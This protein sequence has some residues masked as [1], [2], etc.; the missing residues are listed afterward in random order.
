[1]SQKVEEFKS[2]DELPTLVKLSK[3]IASPLLAEVKDWRECPT[4]ALLVAYLEQERGCLKDKLLPYR[5]ALEFLRSI[6]SSN[7]M[8]QLRK[9]GRMLYKWERAHRATLPVTILIPT[10]RQL[11]SGIVSY[12]R[13]QE[14]LRIL[15]SELGQEMI[16]GEEE[17]T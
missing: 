2:E 4:E 7:E 10:I 14:R 8:A 1:M 5:E 3:Q 6:R 11:I 16:R 12:R 9:I 13:S 15:N 17:W